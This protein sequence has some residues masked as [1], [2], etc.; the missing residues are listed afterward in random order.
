MSKGDQR[1]GKKE[2]SDSVPVCY[3]CDRWKII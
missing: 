1:Q 2:R 3:R